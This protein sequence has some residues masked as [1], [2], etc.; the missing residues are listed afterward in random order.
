MG[1]LEKVNEQIKREIS[2]I[3]QEELSDPR[4]SFVSITHV[5]VSKD[6]RTAKVFFSVL[7]SGAQVKSAQL[8]LDK[9]RSLIRRELG[10]RIKMRFTPELTFKYDDS[11]QFGVQ[12]EETIKEIH[13]EHS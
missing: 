6:L 8:G 9:A 3:M 1:R 4:L 2:F 10:R 11:L 13:D 7:G 5:D 12:L